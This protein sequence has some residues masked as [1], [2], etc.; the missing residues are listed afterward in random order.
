MPLVCTIV[1]LFVLARGWS[2]QMPTVAAWLAIGCVLAGILRVAPSVRPGTVIAVLG[3]P[4]DADPFGRTGRPDHLLVPVL[5]ARL[6]PGRLARTRDK[7]WMPHPRRCNS[8]DVASTSYGDRLNP[9]E[10]VGP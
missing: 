8:M 7:A 2:H 10:G 9:M 5:S 3:V 6:N 4:R 1:S